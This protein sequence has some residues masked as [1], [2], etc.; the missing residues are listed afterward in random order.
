MRACVCN[1]CIFAHCSV[2]VTRIKFCFFALIPWYQ[3]ASVNY[4]KQWFFSSLVFYFK[5][6]CRFFQMHFPMQICTFKKISFSRS[7]LL[8][9]VPLEPIWV[10]LIFK[11]FVLYGI[12]LVP[13]MFY[14]IWNMNYSWINNLLIKIL[15][16]TESLYILS[17]FCWSVH[18]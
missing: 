9:W 18:L 1:W 5:G 10:K 7:V 2:T 6:G 13:Q 17:I 15:L 3:G 14:G 4:H 16:K 8:L 11:H 12:Q